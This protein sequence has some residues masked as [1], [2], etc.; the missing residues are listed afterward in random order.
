MMDLLAETLKF[1]AEEGPPDLS[2]FEPLPAERTRTAQ[3]IL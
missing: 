3:A 1:L 2:A